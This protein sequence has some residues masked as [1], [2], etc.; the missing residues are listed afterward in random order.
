MDVDKM[1]AGSRIETVLI[2][3]LKKWAEALQNATIEQNIFLP[4]DFS[5]QY[6]GCLKCVLKNDSFIIHLGYSRTMGWNSP[7]SDPRDTLFNVK[8]FESD[9]S[10]PMTFAKNTFIGL[11]DDSIIHLQSQFEQN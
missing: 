10:S 5:D 3:L 8:D 9:G 2:N 7:M 1:P 4:Y 11:I 6:T